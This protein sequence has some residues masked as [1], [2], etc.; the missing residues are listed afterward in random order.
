MKYLSIASKKWLYYS[1]VLFGAMLFLWQ[2]SMQAQA[3]DG[4]ARF[5]FLDVGQGDSILIITSDNRRIL[6]DGGPTTDLANDLGPW[7]NPLAPSIDMMLLSH[8]HDD[9]VTGFIDILRRYPVGQVFYSGAV[10]FYA[11]A[12]RAWLGILKDIGM[13]PKMLMAGQVL[14]FTSEENITILAPQVSWDGQEADDLNDTSVVVKYCYKLVCLLLTG[15]ATDEVEQA[16][17]H[18]DQDVRAQ[19]LKVAHHGSRYSSSVEWLSAVKPAVAIIQ[20][21]Q[22]NSFGHPHTELLQRLESQKIPLLRTDQQGEIVIIT[23]GEKWWQQSS[24]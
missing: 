24:Q 17:L 23:D 10:E 9:H 6:V 14:N 5:V 13:R 12:Y 22:D 1:L 21:G 7:L 15:D 18:S 11:P 16:I 4:L 2:Y 20:A 8:G 19:I 3:N